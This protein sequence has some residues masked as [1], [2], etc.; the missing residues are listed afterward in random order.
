MRMEEKERENL[1]RAVK[2]GLLKNC[3]LYTSPCCHWGRTPPCTDAILER[4]I[5]R[6]V[7][8]C[9]DP[10]PLVDGK[11]VR[12]LREAGVEVE[13]GVLEQECWRLNEVF[14]HFIQH[15]SLIHI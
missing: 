1:C 14:F 3:L 15:L 13:T 10:N 6:V 4:G 9:T 11:G 5:A 2:T 8:G 12:L 7:V